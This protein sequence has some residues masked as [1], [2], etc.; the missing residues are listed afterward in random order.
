MT[1][2]YDNPR[3]AEVQEMLHV[4]LEELRTQYGDSD[5]LNQYFINQSRS[6]N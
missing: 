6:K 1:S 4:R 2:I 5:T 3:Y